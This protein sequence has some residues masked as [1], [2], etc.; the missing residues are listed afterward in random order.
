VHSNS[1]LQRLNQHSLLQKRKKIKRK[2]K[3]KIKKKIKV[4][5]L[6]QKEVMLIKIMLS[7]KKKRKRKQDS[8][9]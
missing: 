2:I 1:A 8:W 5:E 6:K 7:Q 9:H 3:R 4:K